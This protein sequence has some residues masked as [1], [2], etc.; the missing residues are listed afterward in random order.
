MRQSVPTRA[1]HAVTHRHRAQEVRR[2]TLSRVQEEAVVAVRPAQTFPHTYRREGLRVRIMQE[3]VCA[4]Q[5][6]RSA[7]SDALRHQAVQV[8]YLQLRVF[9]KGTYFHL[10]R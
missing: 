10:E 9:T 1:L 8:Q 4:G 6:A 2:P 5:P 7:P 3:E